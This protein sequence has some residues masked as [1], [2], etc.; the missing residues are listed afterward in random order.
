MFLK[1]KLACSCCAMAVG[2]QGIGTHS[3]TH[4]VRVNG[5]VPLEF[6][7]R[8]TAN[9]SLPRRRIGTVRGEGGA[10]SGLTIARYVLQRTSY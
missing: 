2:C 5:C 1:D 10:G 7:A 3:C 6:A 9:G 8:G 4:M